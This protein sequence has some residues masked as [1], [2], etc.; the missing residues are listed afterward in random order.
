MS[1]MGKDQLE[2]GEPLVHPWRWRKAVSVDRC[3]PV[4]SP[5]DES[6][7][8]FPFDYLH[9]LSD[10][11]IG[12]NFLSHR[13]A[14]APSWHQSLLAACWIEGTSVSG[15]TVLNI[16]HCHWAVLGAVPGLRPCSLLFLPSAWKA[17]P[18][19]FYPTHPYSF[20]KIQLKCHPLSE[21]INVSCP[22]R[23]WAPSLCLHVVPDRQLSPNRCLPTQLNKLFWRHFIYTD[24]YLST[25]GALFQIFLASKWNKINT[26]RDRPT[27]R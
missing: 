13:S 21:V 2:T 22:F 25:R 7:C 20:S 12:I 23:L 4:G 17:P 15:T 8:K 24:L 3:W 14:C 1:C 27:D 9:F 6:R 19:F 10:I 5:G 16:C 11:G 18:S 26:D